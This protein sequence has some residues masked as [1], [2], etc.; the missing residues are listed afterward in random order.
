M[1]ISEQ[2]IVHTLPEISVRHRGSQDS[3]PG[4]LASPEE[5][6]HPTKNEKRRA[7]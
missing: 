3:C 2:L 5:N 7:K 6:K 4:A 1:F